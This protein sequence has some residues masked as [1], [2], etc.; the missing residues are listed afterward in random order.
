VRGG[1]AAGS[2]EQLARGPAGGQR[3][4]VGIRAVRF[5]ERAAARHLGPVPVGERARDVEVLDV[6]GAAER[7]PHGRSAAVAPEDEPG[8]DHR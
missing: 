6:L 3:T 5:G 8:G 2:G 7:E 4:D 1:P